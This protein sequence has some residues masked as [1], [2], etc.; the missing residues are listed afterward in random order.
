MRFACGPIYY[1]SVIAEE[2][3]HIQRDSSTRP[4]R[5]AVP[6]IPRWTVEHVVA[7]L[8]GMHRWAE[9]IVATRHYDGTGHRRGTDRGEA[10]LAWFEEG[11]EKLIATLSQAEEAEKCGNFSPGSLGTVGFWHR[12]QAHET[13]M[14]RWD[15]EAAVGGHEPIDAGFATDG[16]D[17]LFH[18]FTRTRGKQVLDA[19]VRIATSNTGS[20][21]VLAPAHKPG[22]VDLVD[23]P[24]EVVATLSG[25]A[26][27][28]L[29][30]L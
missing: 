13:T 4:P 2:A 5:C 12:R 1:L 7:H 10:L 23:D 30:A 17:E 29:L 15:V 6:H 25:P 3:S 14:H 26:E 9:N 8:G 20:S 18:I 16:V 19:P 21:W 27:R 11:V 28:M 22:R 24:G